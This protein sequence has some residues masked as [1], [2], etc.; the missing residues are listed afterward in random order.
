MTESAFLGCV[1]NRSRGERV[2]RNV[3]SAGA[4]S[5]V[6]SSSGDDSLFVCSLDAEAS[7]R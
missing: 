7:V 5:V 4:G 3:E 6:E 2:S 1:R